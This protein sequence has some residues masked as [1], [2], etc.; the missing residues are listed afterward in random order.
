MSSPKK[1][2]HTRAPVSHYPQIH[3]FR[4]LFKGF[5]NPKKKT[6]SSR[7]IHHRRC[8][9][10]EVE[11][12]LFWKFQ[13]KLLT[14]MNHPNE[15]CTKFIPKCQQLNS[16]PFWGF[17]PPPPEP[18]LHW[19]WLIVVIWRMHL[20][21]PT[22]TPTTSWGEIPSN[23]VDHRRRRDRF[24]VHQTTPD[25]NIVNGWLRVRWVAFRRV[26]LNLTRVMDSRWQEMRLENLFENCNG[27]QILDTCW[28]DF[29]RVCSMS[30][31][32]I[33]LSVGMSIKSSQT[34][35]QRF[36]MTS[37]LVTSKKCPT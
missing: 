13:K 19:W 34:T 11:L 4:T 30:P 36:S 2:T 6:H 12:G 3:D 7:F 28:T 31:C 16:S 27:S 14:E 9:F 21:E 15:L 35:H 32:W 18:P 5:V 25:D 26:C 8:P 20:A 10:R 24:A 37:K 23:R 29:D 33:F 17:P 22:A 1:P